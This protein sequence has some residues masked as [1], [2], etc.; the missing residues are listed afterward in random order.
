MKNEIERLIFLTYRIVQPVLIFHV[1][2]LSHEILTSDDCLSKKS[3]CQCFVQP[4]IQI[5]LLQ[6]IINFLVFLRLRLPSSSIPEELLI[7]SMTGLHQ[8]QQSY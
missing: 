8:Q 2:G 6:Q 4:V 3:L 7:S 1:T 5:V